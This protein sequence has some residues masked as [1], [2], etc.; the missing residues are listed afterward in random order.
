MGR[1]A[2][3]ESFD[4]N[5]ER[6]DDKEID[7]L[8]VVDGRTDGLGDAQMGGGRQVAGGRLGSAE[9]IRTRNGDEPLLRSGALLRSAVSRRWRGVAVPEW[10]P[11]RG[12]DRSLVMPH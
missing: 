10:R 11:F 7:V 3:P 4:D 8:R 9:A 6:A 12:E 5:D 2:F 1:G